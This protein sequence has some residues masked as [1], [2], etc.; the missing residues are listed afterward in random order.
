[1]A[2]DEKG[3]VNLQRENV[4][5]ENQ[6]LLSRM[7]WV[8][9]YIFSNKPSVHLD[10]QDYIRLLA[11][12]REKSSSYDGFVITHG[13]DLLEETAYFLDLVFDRTIP[14][15]VTGAMRSANEIGSDGSYN[16]YTSVQVAACD[17]SKGKGVLVVM[18]GEI[19][20]ARFVQKTH[21]WAVHSFCSPE[22]GPLGYVT[23]SGIR[24][25]S[26][27]KDR[28]SLDFIGSFAKVGLVKAAFAMNSDILNFLINTGYQ[29]LVIEGIGLGQ[30][31]P[32]MIQGI[33]RA[34][35]KGIP[36]VMA[37]RSPQGATLPVYG[38]PGG[39]KDLEERGVIYTNGYSA[40]KARIKLM[41]YLAAHP[42]WTHEELKQ[43]FSK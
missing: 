20:A 30:V 43:L 42:Q 2:Q 41:V 5:L 35:G 9:F 25:L 10:Q 40:Q 8:D 11:L 39:G 4:L 17:E 36:V 38:Y 22:T 12:L 3:K 18:N 15:V 28:D 16:L 13:T 26:E 33:E 34:I 37:S 14:L 32:H 29:G 31:P 23:P 24:Y 7:A 19:H 1:M 21:T 6:N 27:K